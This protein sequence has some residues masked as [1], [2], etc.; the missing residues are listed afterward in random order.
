MDRSADVVGIISNEDITHDANIMPTVGGRRIMSLSARKFISALQWIAYGLL[1]VLFVTSL[2]DGTMNGN[3]PEDWVY[4]D[5]DEAA[6]NGVNANLGYMPWQVYFA[7]QFVATAVAL[8]AAIWEW[9]T[10][11]GFAFIGMD[12]TWNHFDRGSK[13]MAIKRARMTASPFGAAYNNYYH[14]SVLLHITLFA[15]YTFHMVFDR[16]PNRFSSV[17]TWAW[18]NYSAILGYY[19]YNT[20]KETVYTPEYVVDIMKLHTPHLE[21][22]EQIELE[23]LENNNLEEEERGRHRTSAMRFSNSGYVN[24]G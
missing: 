10:Y 9:R 20:Y 1:T 3:N 17:W 5:E 18:V 14:V 6:A 13:D 12:L 23:A 2:V 15:L 16:A 7:I 19:M 22:E 8:M 11:D 21:D 24:V 4:D